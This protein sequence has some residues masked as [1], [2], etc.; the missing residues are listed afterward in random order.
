M[1]NFGTSWVRLVWGFSVEECRTVFSLGPTGCL[2][3]KEN[4][5][6]AGLLTAMCMILARFLPRWRSVTPTMKQGVIATPPRVQEKRTTG[7]AKSVYILCFRLC[8]LFALCKVIYFLPS[9]LGIAAV[10][11]KAAPKERAMQVL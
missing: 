9:F 1:V 3:L 2:V 11:E 6:I 8:I 4:Q 7:Y 5:F 10:R